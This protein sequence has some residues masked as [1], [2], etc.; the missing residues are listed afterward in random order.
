MTKASEV[1]AL[2]LAFFLPA[3]AML[4]LFFAPAGTG[5]GENK[6][7]GRISALRWISPYSA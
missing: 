1:R 2:R 5:A 4:E 6:A 3:V 7:T